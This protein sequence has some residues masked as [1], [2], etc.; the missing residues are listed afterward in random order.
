MEG[1][2]TLGIRHGFL[3]LVNQDRKEIWKLL[4]SRDEWIQNEEWKPHFDAIVSKYRYSSRFA[5]MR[6]LAQKETGLSLAEMTDEALSVGF[7]VDGL[8]KFTNITMEHAETMEDDELKQYNDLMRR[9]VSETNPEYS[10]EAEQLIAR[11]FALPN[12]TGEKGALSRDEFIRL[13]HMADFSLEDMQFILLRVLGDN[14]V[15]FKPSTAMDLIDMYGFITHAKLAQVEELKAWYCEKLGKVKK[16][17][18]ESKPL[19][20][21]RVIVETL[22]KTFTQWTPEKQNEEFRKWLQQQAPTLDLKSKT[23]RLVYMNLAAYAYIQHVARNDEPTIALYEEMCDDG[24][25]QDDQFYND[26]KDLS[27]LQEYHIVTKELFFENGTPKLDKCKA[28]AAK[29]IRENA[30]YA[31]S[32]ATRDD[33][34]QLYYHVLHVENGKITARGELN[35]DSKERITQILMDQLVPTKSDLLYMLWFVAEDDWIGN[36]QN[37]AERTKLMN[38]FLSAAEALLKAAYLPEFYP[39]N[40]LEETMLL[41][42]ALGGGD[43]MPAQVYESICAAF[44]VVKK[45]AKKKAKK[46][47]T[48]EKR[49]IVAYYYALQEE[50]RSKKE[51]KMLCA[52]H[53]GISVKTVESY[54]QAYKG[55]LLDK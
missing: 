43:R 47:T 41:S 54:D 23:A 35:K 50:H 16:A 22:T 29:L 12:R 45:A 28:V 18:Y 48:E 1:N 17:A 7:K 9:Y 42:L 51:C 32:S 19:Y 13:G 55:G 3:D 11:A 4:D 15:G 44:K 53:Y 14:E 40:I 36:V 5:F 26:M 21:T 20:Y 31:S 30:G 49:E 46:K 39:P 38:N 10:D 34:S 27:E 6:I 24:Y 8:G 2:R 37:A 52:E 33:N 25:Y